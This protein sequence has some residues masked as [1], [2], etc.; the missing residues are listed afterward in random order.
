MA[1]F[2]FIFGIGMSDIGYTYLHRG[3]FKFMPQNGP[4]E[5]ISPTN[6]PTIY[7]TTSA[8]M[9]GLGLLLLLLSIYA[10]FLQFRACRGN[11]AAATPLHRYGSFAFTMLIMLVVVI[12]IFSHH[13]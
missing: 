2:F 7:W 9:L 5:I 1:G 11:T 4:V 3:S 12:M 8:G 6:H 10:A 13:R